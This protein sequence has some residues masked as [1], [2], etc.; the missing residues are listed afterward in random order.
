MTPPR[1][2]LKAGAVLAAAA[3]W[4]YVSTADRDQ[5][6]VR[7]LTV[8]P[9]VRGAPASGYVVEAV[10]VEP[11]AVQVVGPRSTIERRDTVTTVPVDVSGRRDT[12]AD[13][14]TLALPEAVRLVRPTGVRVTVRI[15]SEEGM[16]K[17]SSR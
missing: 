4:V 3:A 8:A 10:V 14:V 7:V 12:V 15:R 17:E 9:D 5:R 11:K 1:L 16:R 6:A 2:A 13:T